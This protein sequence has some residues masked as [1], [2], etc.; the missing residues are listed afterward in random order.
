MKFKTTDELIA[1]HRPDWR[2]IGVGAGLGLMT[3]M[4]LLSL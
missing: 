4:V 3:L 1:S 2:S